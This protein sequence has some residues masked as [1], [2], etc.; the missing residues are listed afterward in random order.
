M[1]FK[2][3]DIEKLGI[4]QQAAQ[5]G[6][7]KKTAK[8]LKKLARP[9]RTEAETAFEPILKQIAAARIKGEQ[10]TSDRLKEFGS[11]RAV[12]TAK[13]A[14]DRFASIAAEVVI[15]AKREAYQAARIDAVDLLKIALDKATS[16]TH[17]SI[18]DAILRRMANGTAVDEWFAQ[19]GPDA[20]NEAR[21]KL[22]EGIVA[23]KQVRS[24]AK[25]LRI[26]LRVPQ[27]RAML[28]AKTETYM[29]R[30]AAI[31]NAYKASKKQGVRGWIRRERKDSR[32]CA[33]C[34]ALDGKFYELDDP[35]EWHPGCRGW[36]E[37]ATEF[38]TGPTE[39]V[40]DWFM[41]QPDDLKAGIVGRR[42]LIMLKQG[43]ITIDDF[44]Q[45][46]NSPDWGKQ[47]TQRS[48]AEMERLGIIAPGD[49]LPS[50]S[51]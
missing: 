46:R 21:R 14:I 35:G 22:I 44:V 1:A 37:P 16:P 51:A 47:V 50:Q 41:R 38:N 6:R 2:R 18:P 33:A 13:E 3:K 8:T 25:D 20:A 43:I 7:D 17:P 45:R 42:G 24:I 40:R 29:I 27:W 49:G 31:L 23:G 26:A 9:F 19:F 30:R 28:I 36:S 4:E 5:I 10:V 11:E 39:T 15:K 12:K 32:T 34:I 48:Y